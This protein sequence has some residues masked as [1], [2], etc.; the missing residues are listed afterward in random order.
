MT[1]P[2]QKDDK[3]SYEVPL[4]QYFT[5][6]SVHT[7]RAGYEK[8]KFH[9]Q[10]NITRALLFFDRKNVELFMK[11]WANMVV[12]FLQAGAIDEKYAKAEREEMSTFTKDALHQGAQTVM[13]GV[14]QAASQG[15]FWKAV[16]VLGLGA[17]AYALSKSAKTRRL[18]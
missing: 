1:L 16:A 7:D 17:G 2:V 9:I 6:I 4:L 5:T 3:L 8:I 14:K 18:S 12:M 13:R 10:R 15:W 11:D